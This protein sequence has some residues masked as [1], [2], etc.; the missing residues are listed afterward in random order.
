MSLATVFCGNYPSPQMMVDIDWRDPITYGRLVADSVCSPLEDAARGVGQAPNSVQDTALKFLWHYFEMETHER[1]PTMSVT[2]SA[3]EEFHALVQRA[4]MLINRDAI[5]SLPM[6]THTEFIVRQALLSYKDGESASPVAITGY[7]HDQGLVRLSYCVPRPSSSERFSVD[8]KR[9]HGTYAKFRSCNFFRRTL[10]YERIVWLP[11]AKG[12]SI[13]AVIEGQITPITVLSQ[14]SARRS[15]S[16]DEG[17]KSLLDDARIAYPPFRNVV[18]ALPFSVRGAMAMVVRWLARTAIVRRRFANAWVFVDGEEEAD[19]NAEHLYRWVFRSHPE[20]NSWFLMERS[21]HDWERLRREG[22]R[23]MPK[24]I[25][26]NL[27]ILN[28][29]HILSSH[30]NLVHGALDP[31]LYGDLMCFRFTYLTHGVH[32]KDRSHWLNKQP[33]D[34]MLATTPM[35]YE[36]VASDGSPYVFCNREVRRT[37][38]PRHD[39]L[40]RL[41]SQLKPEEVNWIIIMPTWRSRLAKI[42]AAGLTSTSYVEIEKSEYVQS[43]GSLLK[44]KWL[45]DLARSYGKRLV[46]MPHPGA[47]SFLA[48]FRIPADVSIITKKDMRIQD[49]FTRACALITDYSTVAFELA[50]LRRPIIY[51]QFDAERFFHH[52]H[53]LREGYFSYLRDGFGPVVTKESDVVM[54]LEHVL[55][56]R[57][58]PESKYLQR[59]DSALVDRDGEACERV[60]NSVVDIRIPRA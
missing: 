6:R 23:L 32:D 22:F 10:F 55:A 50:Y 40:L 15:Q 26:R 1:S 21:S 31:K 13:E 35:E 41:A 25:L 20:I 14:A 47:V 3:A 5:K 45:Q 9:V 4:M 33:F 7:D 51:Y 30:A 18:K 60:F 39:N 43:W 49:V 28:S 17:M 54:E 58:L 36:A 8:G 52:D 38:L 16:R 2:P 56:N 19:D 59:I 42:A 53:G 48:A 12:R 44:N 29:D 27:L 11:A 34:R 37:G 57:C 46:F 24:G